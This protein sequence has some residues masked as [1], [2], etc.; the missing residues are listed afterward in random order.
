MAL[1]PV[2][3]LS[4]NDWLAALVDAELAAYDPAAARLRLPPELR[5]GDPDSPGVEAR[6][7]MLLVRALR[8]RVADAVPADPLEAFVRPLRE[9]VQLLLDITIVLERPWEPARRRAELAMLFVALDGDG[10]SAKAADPARPHK[11]SA[12]AVRRAFAVAAGA[13]VERCWPPGDPRGGLPL[14]AGLL[15]IE[16]RQL[17][18][19][20]IDYHRRGAIDDP[21]V[22]RRLAQARL[23]AVALFE[24][25]A[26]AAA[27]DAPRDRSALRGPLRQLR[28]LEL[29]RPL[30]ARARAALASPLPAD[31]LVAAIH[32]RLRPFVFEQ[33]LLAGLAAQ[34]S[35]GREAFVARFAEVAGISR[36][37]IVALQAE[38]AL[39]YATEQRWIEA[40]PPVDGAIEDAV[41]RLAEAFSEN[42]EA[43]VTELK[44][45]GELTQLLAKA[46]AGHTLDDTERAKVKAQLIDL[47]KAVPAIAIFAAPGGMLLLPLL[48]KV[49]PFNVLPSAWEPK[50]PLLPPRRGSKKPASA[51]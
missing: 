17:A 4:Q 22:R 29:P 19:L 20:A 33:L 21:P 43:L 18:R 16:R 46:A 35:P 7:R 42:L 26:S 24:A 36:D 37:E 48:A 50:Q 10:S 23:E 6:A 2:L 27:A 30:A 28:R 38:A 15:C 51:A 14:R 39:L 32:P 25:L 49:L 8:P 11:K 1:L 12:A 41:E 47:A 13:L 5:V 40:P 34:S 31:D 45:T 3:D 44:Q 9:H